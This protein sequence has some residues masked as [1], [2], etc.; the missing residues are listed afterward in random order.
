MCEI[1]K[2]VVPNYFVEID[3]LLFL[4]KYYDPKV[5]TIKIDKEAPLLD[6]TR[7]QIVTTFGL[8]PSATEDININAPC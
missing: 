5:R 2:L 8:N 4:T 3:F 6:I 7:S 1:G